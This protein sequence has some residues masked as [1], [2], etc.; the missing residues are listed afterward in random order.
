MVVVPIIEVKEVIIREAYNI[1]IK[2]CR[3]ILHFKVI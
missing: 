3:I 1:N 2:K